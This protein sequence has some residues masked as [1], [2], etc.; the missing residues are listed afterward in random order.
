[1]NRVFEL[2]GLRYG[3]YPE[4]G[5]TNAGDTDDPKRKGG[6]KLGGVNKWCS[7]GKVVA[8]AMRKNKKV[9]AKAKGLVRASR[10]A[11]ASAKG[12]A[13]ASELAKTCAELGEVITS[14]VLR[15]ASARMLE[16][17]R[18]EWRRD[19][20]IPMASCEDNFT[21]FLAW[22]FKV[23]SLRAK[24]LC[25]CNIRDGQVRQVF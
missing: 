15:E 8:L 20:P 24:Y 7:K 16:V 17:T 21:S 4:E 6:A 22:Y 12:L 14:L 18:G 1:M 19:D 11:E 23:F 5:S 10:V 3:S 25:R 13:R 2:S 9:E